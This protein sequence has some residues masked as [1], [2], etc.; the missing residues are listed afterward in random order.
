LE[1]QSLR[2]GEREMIEQALAAVGGNRRR[3]ARRLGIAERTLYRKLK[4]YGMS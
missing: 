3:A 1:P 2:D 4:L